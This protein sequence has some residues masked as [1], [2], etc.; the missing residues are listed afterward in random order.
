MRSQVKVLL[1]TLALGPIV[2]WG[3]QL[4]SR[5][6]SLETF[7]IT[8][9]D[10]QGIQYLNRD[11]VVSRLAIGPATSVWSDNTEW[12]ERVRAHPLVEHVEIRRRFLPNG[13]RVSIRERRPV[14]LAPTPT[15]EPVD[16]YGVRLPLDPTRYAIDLPVIAATRFP[17]EN[18]SV[19]PEEVRMLAA[20]LEHLTRVDE[21]FAGEISTVERLPD[22]ALRIGLLDPN[23]E[24]WTPRGV[25]AER[26]RDAGA[27]VRHTRAQDPG[28]G[29]VVVDLRYAD[30]I[31]VRRTP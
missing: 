19:F 10:V 7:R 11:T 16:A 14:A 21:E 15:L 9:V 2:A 5:V 31:V 20:E 12:T 24:Y 25:N 4:A 17:P 8:E 30:R 13:L 26:L 23:I 18:A 22:G 3:P 27:A 6:A 28:M 29:P 1:V